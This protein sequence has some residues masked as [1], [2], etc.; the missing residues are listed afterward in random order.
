V[1]GLTAD[2][3][4]LLRLRAP[5]VVRSAAAPFRARPEW[6][7][8]GQRTRKSPKQEEGM[9]RREEEAAEAARRRRVSLRVM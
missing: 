7:V 5:P 9:R 3:R 8:D 1:S 6:Q 2:L 4:E